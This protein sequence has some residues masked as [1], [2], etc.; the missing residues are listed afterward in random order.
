MGIIRTF[1]SVALGESHKAKNTPCQDAALSY[2]DHEKGIYIALVSDGHGNERHFMSDHGSKILIQVALNSIKGFI[3]TSECNL[4]SV[5]FATSAIISSNDDKSSAEEQISNKKPDSQTK[6]M[7]GLIS[8]IMAKWNLAIEKDWN[9][10]TPS[11][12]YM[13]SKNV[14]EASIKDY[15]NGINIEVAY[16][17]TLIAF[18]KTSDFWFAF[19]IGDGTCI[20]FNVSGV[21]FHPIPDDER[22]NGSTTA[23]MCNEDAIESFRYC[24]GNTAEPIAVFLGSDGLDG[25]FGT[26]NEFSIPQLENFYENIIK[27]FV[28][29]GFERTYK[30]IEEALPQ[31]SAKGVTRDDMSLAG[32]VDM[33]EMPKLLPILLKKHKE[34]AEKEFLEAEERVNKKEEEASQKESE[35]KQKHEEITYALQTIDIQN[36]KISDALAIQQ[37]IIVIENKILT[38]AKNDLNSKQKE[39]I[40][41]KEDLSNLHSNLEKVEKEKNAALKKLETIKIEF[42]EIYKEEM[43]D[44]KSD[45]DNEDKTEKVHNDFKSVVENDSLKK[46]SF[47]RKI[48][49]S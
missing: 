4:L 19:Q 44:T 22:Y 37:D 16:G 31:L 47:W 23:S 24:Y 17:C 11:L 42:N 26:M 25:V 10:N 49:L 40:K 2:E 46:K 35:I 38:D 7:K 3:E 43:S 14:P 5:P 29:K 1:H 18:I 33:D 28:K 12:E 34:S 27:T 48:G 15:S 8:S 39:I 6:L 36:K 13:K 45:F 32:V 9:E 20:A 41:A 30:E 21:P